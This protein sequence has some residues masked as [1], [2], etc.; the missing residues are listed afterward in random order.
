MISFSLDKKWSHWKEPSGAG[1]FN[2]FSAAV[3][4]SV[5]ASLLKRYRHA[6]GFCFVC[7]YERKQGMQNAYAYAF[8]SLSTPEKSP[9]HVPPVPLALPAPQ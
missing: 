1:S 9:R 8:N 5:Q 3:S 4:E 7:V 6:F 2:F